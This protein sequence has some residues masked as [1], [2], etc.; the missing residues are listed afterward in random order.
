MRRTSMIVAVFVL[1]LT[2]TM[3]ASAAERGWHVRVFAAGFDP[4]LDVVVPSENPDEVRV[5]ADSALGV[6]LFHFTVGVAY[7][8]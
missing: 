6:E 8:F 1:V 7:S 2:A 4:D 5:T 3:P